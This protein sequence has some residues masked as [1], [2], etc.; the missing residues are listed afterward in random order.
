MTPCL[1]AES[2]SSPYGGGAS[3]LELPEISIIVDGQVDFTDAE[4][5]DDEKLRIDEA[6]IALSGYLYPSIRGDFIA[7]LEQEYV[8]DEVETE[9]DIEEAY[10]SFLDL[11]ADFQALVGRKL[12]NFGRLNPVHPHH[13]AFPDT[14][15]P[16]ANLFG[17]HPWFDDGAELSYLVP[18]PAELYLK[19]SAGVWN[20]RSL[21]HH[22]GEEEEHAEE[23][24]DHAEEEHAEED[25]AH[26]HEAV[27][28]W[29]GEH[30]FTGRA[31]LDLPIN[32][33]LGM[34]IG[35]SLAAG[36][37]GDTTVHGADLVLGYRWPESFRRAKWHT[38]V[39]FTEDDVRG[40]EPVG[41]FSSLTYAPDKN[42][43]VGGRYDYTELLE[44][45]VLDE[46]GGTG[47]LTY[48]LTHTTYLRGA[49]RYIDHAE[50]EE[51]NVVTL[52]L[53]WGIGPH[54]HRLDN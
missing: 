16:V 45:D 11:P 18:N 3:A 40:T 7:A 54:S 22:H 48:F 19:L 47:F 39:F 26:E 38:E 10:V 27:L 5:D 51:E 24:E 53:V 8:G 50:E 2:T 20:G 25:H 23:T 33:E 30:V 49:Y 9:T 31:F 21:E 28:D 36:E 29:G 32:D 15:L 52:Q 14:P 46:W 13:W 37:N 6:E 12:I 44:D 34:G 4:S 1:R 17:D 35:Y 41:L 42:W 43:E